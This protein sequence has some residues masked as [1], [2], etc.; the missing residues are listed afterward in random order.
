MRHTQKFGRKNDENQKVKLFHWIYAQYECVCD[1]SN[2]IISS[3]T[4]TLKQ[5]TAAAA[6]AAYKMFFH[7]NKTNKTK[8]RLIQRK[9]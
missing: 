9:Y 6:A 7:K 1:V 3:H 4:N 2:V 8:K 5:N